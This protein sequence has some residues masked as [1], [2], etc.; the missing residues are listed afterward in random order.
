[1]LNFLRAMPSPAAERLLS[2]AIA[3]LLPHTTEGASSDDVQALLTEARKAARIEPRDTPTVQN[4]KVLEV[5][6]SELDELVLGEG[7]ERQAASRIGERG[8]LPLDQYV[9]TFGADFVDREKLWARRSNI[10]D[11][12]R[13]PDQL[14]HLRSQLPESEGE[15]AS[16]FLKAV[17]SPRRPEDRFHWLVRASRKGNAL[18]V[19]EAYRVYPEDFPRDGSALIDVLRSFVDRYGLAFRVCGEGP[20]LLFLNELIPFIPSPGT[21][22]PTIDLMRNEDHRPI[23]ANINLRTGVVGVLEV[24]LGYMV[25]L[26]LYEATLRRHKVHL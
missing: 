17:A 23:A 25:D 3:Q 21:Q 12:V 13:R 15:L 16:L 18:R 11:V 6:S 26:Q 22:H 8:E 5:L 1:M 7:R 4:A 20:R 9:I 10:E 14:L 19:I 24:I 2:E